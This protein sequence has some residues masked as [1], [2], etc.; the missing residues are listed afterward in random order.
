[1]DKE[2]KKDTKEEQK[3]VVEKSETTVTETTHT[4]D[5]NE[6]SILWEGFK[7]TGAHNGTLLLKSGNVFYAEGTLKSASFEID[8]TSIANADM[9]DDDPYKEKLVG[10]LKSGDFF[11]IEN[12]P[13]ASFVLKS[14]NMDEQNQLNFTGDLTMKS[15]TKSVTFPVTL[16]EEAN[17]LT[18]KSGTFKVNRTEYGIKYKSKNFFKDIKDKFINDEF[19]VSFNVVLKAK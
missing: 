8:M 18:L 16:A 7:P 3:E 5:V 13:T 19:E 15:I 4:V 1:M 12:F 9:A 10:H 6:S 11:D 2:K 14:Q 17:V